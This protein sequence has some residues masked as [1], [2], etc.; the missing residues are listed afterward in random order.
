MNCPYDIDKFE[1]FGTPGKGHKTSGSPAYL[2][3]TRDARTGAPRVRLSLSSD[4]VKRMHECMEFEDRL[5]YRVSKSARAIAL[6]PS[7][8]GVMLSYPSKNKGTRCSISVSKASRTLLD[9]F[10]EFHYAHLIPEYYD[11]VT[12]FRPSGKVEGGGE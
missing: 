8:D 9:M 12:V 4:V 3:F 6:I 10:G 5:E 11:G 7:P 2:A 1:S